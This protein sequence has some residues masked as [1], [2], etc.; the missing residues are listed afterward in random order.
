MTSSVHGRSDRNLYR[1]MAVPPN[2]ACGAVVGPAKQSNN[3]H[4]TW[5]T[6]AAVYAQDIIDADQN[7]KNGLLN[8]NSP[9]PSP[10]PSPPGE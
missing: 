1:K 2:R 8:K 3:E 9:S 10:T 4:M 7:L 6:Y 5:I